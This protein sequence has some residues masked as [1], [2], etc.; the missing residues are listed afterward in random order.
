LRVI[1]STFTRTL[2]TGL[3]DVAFSKRST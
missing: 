1:L 2:K 3:F